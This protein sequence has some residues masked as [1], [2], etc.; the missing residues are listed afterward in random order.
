MDVRETIS[1]YGAEKVGLTDMMSLLLGVNRMKLEPLLIEESLENLFKLSLAELEKSTSRGLAAKIYALGEVIRRQ[2]MFSGEAK[3]TINSPQD[4]YSLLSAE[5]R[6]LD[7]EEVRV[8]LLNTKNHVMRI[9]TISIG[10]LNA[11]VVHPRE[12]FKAAVKQSA[13]SMILVHNHPSGDP[14]PSG[15]DIA[16][17]KRLYDVGEMMGIEVL[18]HIIIGDGR[19]VSL[20]ERGV[21]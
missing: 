7:R 1:V 16:I 14:T 2:R 6:Y 17:T 21:M 3:P 18:D 15:E 19:Y 11:S 5:M 9:E 4:V 13:N 12:V 20:K 8:L 10:S